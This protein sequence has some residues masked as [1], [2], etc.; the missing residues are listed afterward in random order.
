MYSALYKIYRTQGERNSAGILHLDYFT[1]ECTA[2]V[3]SLVYPPDALDPFALVAFVV[4][5]L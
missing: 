5:T 2:P 3:M 1:S 4:E